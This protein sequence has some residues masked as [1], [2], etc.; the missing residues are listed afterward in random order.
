MQ[1]QPLRTVEGVPIVIKDYGKHNH[2]A[3]PDFFNARIKIGDQ[4]WARNVEM[5]LRSS[6]WYVHHHET[7]E[8]Y[9]TVILHVVWEDDANIFRTDKS[10]V[11]TL[12]LKDYIPQ[13]LLNSYG[14]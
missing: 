2:L 1:V 14:E 4:L 5:H 9:N 3:G 8:K 11:P 6:D 13:S 7:D 10:K 12:Q